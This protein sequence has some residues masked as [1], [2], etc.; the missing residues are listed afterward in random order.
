MSPRVAPLI[1]ASIA[2]LVVAACTGTATSVSTPTAPVTA[3]VTPP[4]TGPTPTPVPTP[5]ALPTPTPSENAGDVDGF[6]PGP[7]LTIEFPEED[8][9]KVGLEDPTARA[10]RLVI[11][12]TD[13]LSQD[14][15]EILVET[16]DVDP[17]ITVT[18]VQQGDV[19][20]AM[21]LS[22]Y[23]NGTATTGGCHATLG[24]CIDSSAFALPADG[25]GRF[26]IL[27]GMRGATAPL[28]VTGGTAGWPGE[29]FVLGPW[30][31]AEAFPW[32]P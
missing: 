30:S 32:E 13:D 29:P 22:G 6:G 19:V 21:D 9:L 16:G 1:A 23:A 10:W 18:E 31:N 26:S 15:L 28:V 4:V 14:R 17:S 3:P 12:G 11:T 7:E 8:L 27:L 25:S 2:V 20:D 24:V 5:A